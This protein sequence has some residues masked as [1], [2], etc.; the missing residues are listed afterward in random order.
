MP[1]EFGDS[2]VN[3]MW[4]KAKVSPKHDKDLIRQDYAGAWIK[5]TEYGQKSEYG[6]VIDLI[7]PANVGGS[8]SNPKNLFISH[9]RNYDARDHAYPTWTSA[10][11]ASP[12]P[13]ALLRNVKK[14]VKRGAIK[15]SSGASSASSA[16]RAS[17]A[18]KTS[19]YKSASSSASSAH[20]RVNNAKAT[21]NTSASSS[22]KYAGLS[23]A[24]IHKIKKLEQKLSREKNVAAQKVEANRRR[25]Q[26]RIRQ[27]EREKELNRIARERAAIQREKELLKKERELKAEYKEKLKKLR[28]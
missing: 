21:S 28:R 17:S 22:S 14:I 4:T 10:Y 11:T 3:F 26:Q 24:Q 27:Q 9:W 19:T 7:K 23:P 2:V 8:Q 20:T 18:T 5:R 13:G 12:E 6:W 15:K 1:Y 16:S 25:E